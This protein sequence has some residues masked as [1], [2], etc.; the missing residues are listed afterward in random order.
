M[1]AKIGYWVVTPR[2]GKPVEINGLWINALRVMEWLADKLGDVAAKKYKAAAEKGESNFD[3][4]FWN[5]KRGHYLDTVDPDDASLRP[6]Q[7]IAMSLPFAPARG[8]H[9]LRALGVV[10]QQ[11]VTPRGLR[12][13]GPSEPGYQGRY[14]GALPQLDAAYHQGTV[15]PWLLGPYLSACAKLRGSVVDQD[16]W[17][18]DFSAMLQEG[19]LGGITEVYDGDEVRNTGGCPWQAWSV[20]EMLRAIEESFV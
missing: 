20:S 1:D 11:L 12:T 6:N 17:L 19:G 2:H 8:D 15:W 3:R 10:E 14:E 5:E 7:V 18:A 4:K 9:A 13:L 16:K